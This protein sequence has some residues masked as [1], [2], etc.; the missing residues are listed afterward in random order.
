MN[1]T[2]ITP[3]V[4]PSALA[5]MAGRFNM[6]PQKLYGTLKNTIFKG[7][8]D[9]ELQAL[10]IVANSYNLNPMTREI[11]GFS[12]KG[13]GIVPVVSV[14]GWC[15]IINEHPQMDGVE[16]E[17]AIDQNGALNSCTAIIYR[18]DRSHPTRVTEFLAEVRR[19]T[20]PWKMEHRMLRHK[21]LIQCARVAFGFSGIYDEDEAERIKVANAHVVA[22]N[23]LPVFGP[24]QDQP[25][26][27]VAPK[28]RRRT[29]KAEA[30]PEPEPTQEPEQEPAPELPVFEATT[31]QR[32]LH[33]ALSDA[34]IAERDF[35]AWLGDKR[36][37]KAETVNSLHEVVAAECLENFHSIQEA[38]A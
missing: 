8:S 6:E 26:Q 34:G 24:T 3:A 4:K 19:N 17:F 1:N 28:A 21:A 20:E 32:K 23:A 18:K 12:G 30:Q 13:G 25:E 36:G 22:T 16:F 33:I 7:A 29:I 31:P 35:I 37:L 10:V 5:V 27:E 2:Q 9:E 14:D 11:F 38:L 15:R